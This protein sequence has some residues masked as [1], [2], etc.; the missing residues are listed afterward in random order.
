MTSSSARL[1]GPHPPVLE[2]ARVLGGGRNNDRDLPTVGHGAER[3]VD[4]I[5][6]NL[7]HG[8]DVEVGP[9]FL[10]FNYGFD[11]IAGRHH[12][13]A[14]CFAQKSPHLHRV[15]VRFV[16]A[17]KIEQARD[18]A[19]AAVSLFRNQGQ[20]GAQFAVVAVFVLQQ[21]SIEQNHAQWVV[22]FVGNARRQTAHAGQA[23]GVHQL[24]LGAG[25][26]RIRLVKF[27][28]GDF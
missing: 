16:F 5:D 22:H 25:Q 2:I 26:L 27:S 13:T 14:Q 4:Q 28:N 18:D 6:H 21:V 17:G 24:F 20:I 9:Q 3:V 8:H 15:Q 19:L 7:S 1:A 10:V 11:G 23:F 12:N